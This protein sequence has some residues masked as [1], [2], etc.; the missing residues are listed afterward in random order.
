[1]RKAVGVFGIILILVACR[2]QA[3]ANC[4]EPVTTASGVV[5]GVTEENGSCAWKGVPYAAAPVEE[6]RWKAP[7]P[8]PG[9]SGVREADQF[10]AMCMQ[11]G[12]LGMETKTSKAGMSEDCLYLNIWR[13][14]KPG[15]YPVMYWVHG[16]GYTIGTAVTPMYW[17]D[18]LAAEGDVVVVTI[19]YRLNLFGFFAS[20]A[21][22]EE[23][24][25]KSVGGYATLDQVE[26]LKWVSRN[27]HQFGG[28]P[29]NVTIFGESA[30]G[31]S[32]CT[33]LA[34]PLAKGLFQRAILQS[35]GCTESEDLDKGYEAGGKLAGAVGCKLDD[36][37]CLRKVPAKK[38]LGKLASGMGGAGNKPH[39]DGYVLTGTPLSMIRA[40]N[41]NRASF[42]AGSTRDEFGN[43]LKLIGK[44]RRVRPKDYESALVKNF[45][46]KDEDAKEL[47]SLY[48][49]SEFDNRPVAAYGH[50]MGCDA[51]LACP[52]YQGLVAAA[53]QQKGTYYYRFDYD[54]MRLGKYMGS[55]HSAEIPFIFDTLDRLPYKIFYNHKNI[56]PARELS[57]I[58]QA[59]W[60]NF[61]KTG[62]PN[63]PGL[64]DWPEFSPGNQV[65]Q[66]LDIQTRTEKSTFAQR[67]EFWDTHEMERPH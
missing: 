1:M 32:I 8:H 48:P 5:R 15:V 26:G 17:G 6:L 47:A 29:G 35:G 65:V 38:L 59:Y 66:I 45:E 28:D 12:L 46:F 20:P 61:A 16:G 42:M 58:V 27:I 19:N 60:L 11:K 3:Q 30:G 34:T 63:A 57:K 39:H 44:Y 56:G 23:D 13:P 43:A 67:C 21:L 41:Y 55:F 62:N 7:Q 54:E 4:S 18:R 33:L 9:W 37:D 31:W 52:T 25:N 49:L 24:P 36:L 51:A 2:A 14:S 22:R 50:A 53:K 10:G 64:A 40:G